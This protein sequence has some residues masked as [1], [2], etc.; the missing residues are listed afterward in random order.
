MLLNYL[1]RVYIKSIYKR[2]CINYEFIHKDPKKN[3][4]LRYETLF[5]L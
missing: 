2:V 3:Y 1:K 4:I 5:T